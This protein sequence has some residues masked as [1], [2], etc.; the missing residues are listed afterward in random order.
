MVKNDMSIK[1][2]IRSYVGKKCTCFECVM[3]LQGGLSARLL[4]MRSDNPAQWNIICLVPSFFPEKYFV[5]FSKSLNFTL[6]LPSDNMPLVKIADMGLHTLQQMLKQEIQMLTDLDFS[7]G[8]K[9]KGG[10]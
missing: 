7:I 8:E 9:L 1:E 3:D 2:L 6:E 5:P 4:F 10:K